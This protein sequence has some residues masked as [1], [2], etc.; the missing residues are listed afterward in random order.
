MKLIKFLIPTFYTI[1]FFYLSISFINLELN[2]MVWKQ[3]DR[4]IIVAFAAFVLVSTFL[5]KSFPNDRTN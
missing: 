1:L 2:F 3:K 5:L 4:E